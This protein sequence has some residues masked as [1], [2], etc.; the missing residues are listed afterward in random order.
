MVVLFAYMAVLVV[1]GAVLC[2]KGRALF[3]PLIAILGFIVGF[4]LYISIAGTSTQD[5][6][7]GLVLGLIAAL[8]ARF[9]YLAGVFLC[10]A[11]AG[12]VIGNFIIGYLPI[13][14]EY[15]KPLLILGIALLIGILAVKWVDFFIAFSTSANGAAL[16]A[17]PCCFMVFKLNDLAGF[18][19]SDA[20]ATIDKVN[21]AM[22]GGFSGNQSLIVLCVSGVLFLI[23]MIIQLKSNSR[24][25]KRK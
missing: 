10:G 24:M 12:V 17:V 4:G 11:L 2:F 13:K 16:M 6:I 21:Q 1:I 14:S 25:P 18:V 7:L 22:A 19:G 8:L 5:I 20:A 3:F 23:G 9:V 15:G